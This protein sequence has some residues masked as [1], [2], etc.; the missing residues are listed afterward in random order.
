MAAM[1]YDDA[2]AERVRSIVGRLASVP[3]TEKRMFGG[4]AFLL[5]GNMA[6]AVQGRNAGLLVRVDPDQTEAL[7]AQPGAALMEMGGRSM[8]G[9]LTVEAAVLAKDTELRRWIKRGV[10]YAT[11]L[12]AK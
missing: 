8:R 3:A 1:A 5:G 11:T 10:D 12:P 6:V 9:W 2:F 4:L 7:L